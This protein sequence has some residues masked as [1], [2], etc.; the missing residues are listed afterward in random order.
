M[1]LKG[2]KML[3]FGLLSPRRHLRRRR[4]RNVSCHPCH[5]VRLSRHHCAKWAFARLTL[6]IAAEERTV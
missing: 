2:M 3:L 4:H 6:T 1:Y 5:N